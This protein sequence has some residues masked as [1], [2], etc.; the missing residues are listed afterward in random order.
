MSNGVPYAYEVCADCGAG[1]GNGKLRS[2]LPLV[3]DKDLLIAS[4]KYQGKT[5]KE[6]LEIDKPY[7][8]WLIKESKA[9]NRIKRA[10]ARLYFNNGYEIPEEGKIYSSYEK[11]HD[12]NV[13]L[14]NE[15]MRKIINI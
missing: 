3:S 7:F 8:V 12:Y 2:H 10:A 4:R 14:G 13:N 15:L 1:P 9:S 5:L 11:S 6:I